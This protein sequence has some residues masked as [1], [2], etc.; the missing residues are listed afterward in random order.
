MYFLNEYSKPVEYWKYNDNAVT[1]PDYKCQRWATI[2]IVARRIDI[3]S[4]YCHVLSSLLISLVNCFKI[5]RIKLYLPLYIYFMWYIYL[6]IMCMLI[7][8]PWMWHINWKSIFKCSILFYSDSG[9][10]L[11]LLL[12]VDNQCI[13]FSLNGDPLPPE[14]DLFVCAR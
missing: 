6:P 1:Y 4:I 5:I 8:M 3:V 10:I 13:I 7:Y 14:S 12:D 9:D 2:H 11:G